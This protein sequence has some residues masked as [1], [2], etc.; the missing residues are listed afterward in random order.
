MMK[1]IKILLATLIVAWTMTSCVD[2]SGQY[3]GQLYTTAQKHAAVNECLVQSKDSA[4][5]HLFTDN[6]FYSYNN[7]AYR[8]DY[9]TV[10]AALMDTL[11]Q[12]G[13]GFLSD[14]LILATNHLASNC[15][16]AMSDALTTAIKEMEYWDYDGLIGGEDGS[17]TQYFKKFKNDDL[18]AA[19]QSPVSI[20]MNVF[21]VNNIWNEMVAQYY[22][23]CGTPIGVDVQ[24]YIINKM[25]DGVYSEMMEEEH[26]IRTDTTHQNENTILFR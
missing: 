5:N 3:V 23:I 4:L 6:G 10:A 11:S 13:L 12:H 8:I 16:T 2:N 21:N 7:G 17:I 15:R 18:K 24:G 19:L 25:L 20:R 26:L 22:S 9:S 1:K 14:S